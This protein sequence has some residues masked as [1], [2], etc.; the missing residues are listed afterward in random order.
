MLQSL[1]LSHNIICILGGQ[2]IARGLGKTIFAFH[3]H[4]PDPNS[5]LEKEGVDRN[6]WLPKIWAI[7]LLRIF[8]IWSYTS[9]SHSKIAN[10]M[11]WIEKKSY[12]LFVLR[13]EKVNQK[14]PK[15]DPK[16][17]YFTAT[18]T[19]RNTNRCFF[20]ITFYLAY[21]WFC[22]GVWV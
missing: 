8:K 7:L 15:T 9:K 2:H 22:F 5:S 13:S 20:K 19:I 6:H 16:W 4:D 21:V 3:G 10:C 18:W 14:T 17:F 11:H 12:Q 1:N